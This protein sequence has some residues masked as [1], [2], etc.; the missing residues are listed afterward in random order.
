L[1]FSRG[2][3]KVLLVLKTLLYQVKGLF[4]YNY[5]DCMEPISLEVVDLVRNQ[6]MVPDWQTRCWETF[7]LQ[8]L[9]LL[10]VQDN[11]GARGAELV[12][13]AE[14]VQLI[15]LFVRFSPKVHNAND[16]VFTASLQVLSVL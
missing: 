2:K 16:T 15:C 4:M 6:C 13:K 5:D 3:L 7:R 11:T 1:L 12:C 9:W 14:R 10:L 8:V